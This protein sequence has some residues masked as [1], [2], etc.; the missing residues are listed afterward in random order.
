MDGS[1]AQSAQILQEEPLLIQAERCIHIAS[2]S[3][4]CKE[5][6]FCEEICKPLVT[7]FMKVLSQ[8]RKIED[9]TSVKGQ[10]HSALKVASMYIRVRTRP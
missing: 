4:K 7:D 2:S 6:K 9:G 5:D 10:M 8:Q 1:S 3:C